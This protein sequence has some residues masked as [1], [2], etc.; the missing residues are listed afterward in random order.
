MEEH[1]DEFELL[2][3][4]VK[5]GEK[6]VRIISGYGPQENWKRE[7]RLPFF[8]TLE[9]EIK[10]AKMNGKYIFIQM[11]ANAKL[12]P[13]VIK[14]DPCQQ[15]DNG[16]I[17]CDILKRNALIVMNGVK[18]KCTGTITRRR[19]TKTS[20][21]ESVIDLIIVCEGMEKLINKVT[22]DEERKNVL[23]RYTKSK[24]GT[25]IKESDH[26]SMITEVNTA[27]NKKKNVLRL[28]TYNFKD[29][30]GL[31]KFKDMT[32]K[33]KFLSEVFTNVDKNIEVTTKQFIKRL[34]YCLSI[35]FRKVRIKG[36]QRNK[37]LEKLFNQRR[38]LRSKNDEASVEALEKV[39]NK[40]SELCAEDNVPLIKEA[41]EGMPCEEGRVNPAKLWKLKKEALEHHM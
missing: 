4:E 22:I 18:D 8:R 26:N 27:W 2:V 13:D 36:T 9:E 5:L 10:K 24:K 21:E 6:D 31:K 38:I 28:E 15:S 14:G 3:V 23:T 37:T 30:D 40:L 39:N 35:C 25:T 20:K 1:S 12:G 41:C 34:G 16:K 19:I 33:D 7:E 17:L 29:K 11:D 32:N